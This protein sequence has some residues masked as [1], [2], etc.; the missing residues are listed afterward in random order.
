M[1]FKTKGNTAQ[2]EARMEQAIDVL[3]TKKYRSIR[4]ATI[5]FNVKRTTL[6]NRF[7][8]HKSR[9]ESHESLQNLSSAEEGE[10]RRW[11]SKLMATGFSPCHSLVR[12][13][14]EAIRNHRL[15][16]VNNENIEL[17]EYPPLGRDWVCNFLN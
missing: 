12:E 8:G 11:I 7:N 1:T 5:D 4:K 17:V 2:Y 13:M 9:R 6:N 3:K 10:L 14:S 16:A 15:C